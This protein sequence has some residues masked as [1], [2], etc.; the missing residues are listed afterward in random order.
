MT[1]ARQNYHADEIRVGSNKD[2]ETF[3]NRKVHKNL[4]DRDNYKN[5]ENKKSLHLSRFENDALQS[6]KQGISHRFITKFYLCYLK[7]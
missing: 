5:R 2:I 1:E 3:P 7:F 4:E 6:T